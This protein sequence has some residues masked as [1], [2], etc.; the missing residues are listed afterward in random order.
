MTR[1]GNP[2]RAGAIE[3]S[4]P[5]FSSDYPDLRVSI[6]DILAEGDRVAAAH[7]PGGEP[8]PMGEPLRQMGLLI[9]R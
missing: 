8:S 9:L 7:E 5:A 4:W 3:A 2:A 6:E 1:R